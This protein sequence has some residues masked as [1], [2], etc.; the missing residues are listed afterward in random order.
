VRVPRATRREELC[1][2]ASRARQRL[3]LA[4]EITKAMRQAKSRPCDQ[5]G[6]TSRRST[7]MPE[8]FCSIRTATYIRKVCSSSGK[9]LISDASSPPETLALDV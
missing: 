2:W 1:R 3:L 5:L 6:A 4:H 8:A 9:V 7:A